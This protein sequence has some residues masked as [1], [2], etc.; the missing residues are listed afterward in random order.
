M[1]DKIRNGVVGVIVASVMWLLL[2]VVAG[3]IHVWMMKKAGIKC[4]Y[5]K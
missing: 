2:E 5:A 1:T 3:V 4:P